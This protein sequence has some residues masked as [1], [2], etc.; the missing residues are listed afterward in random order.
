MHVGLKTDTTWLGGTL[1]L[2]LVTCAQ[3]VPSHDISM[4]TVAVPV[5]DACITNAGAPLALMTSVVGPVAVAGDGASEPPTAHG[6]VAA[7]AVETRAAKM[8]GQRNF[9]LPLRNFERVWAK[10]AWRFVRVDAC[11]P[12]F[13]TERAKAPVDLP[14][15]FAFA[16]KAP[17]LDIA[18]AIHFSFAIS[19]PRKPRQTPEEI[20]D[21]ARRANPPLPEWRNRADAHERLGAVAGVTM[22]LG[23]LGRRPDG[24]S[25]GVHALPR[26]PGG[27]RRGIDCRRR[28]DWWWRHGRRP[29]RWRGAGH[30]PRRRAAHSGWS[31]RRSRGSSTRQSGRAGRPRSS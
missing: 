24:S 4:T 21:I 31:H 10:A 23:E 16:L 1:I 13:S 26:H 18:P 9:A 7:P 5:P 30:R 25:K 6:L 27:I 2:E 17:G 15:A 8:S 11:E 20:G 28:G 29:H 12:S 3:F 22:R 19:L 14:A